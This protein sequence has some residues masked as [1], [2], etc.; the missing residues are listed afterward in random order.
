LH[1]TLNRRL[2]NGRSSDDELNA[3]PSDVARNVKGKHALILA[4]MWYAAPIIATAGTVIVAM[5]QR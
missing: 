4:Y 3:E 2:S 5:V 1:P